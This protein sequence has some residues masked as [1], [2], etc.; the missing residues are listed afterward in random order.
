MS[1]AVK[2]YVIILDLLNS[3]QEGEYIPANTF[4][5][6]FDKHEIPNS[7]SAFNRD[8]KQLQEI[9]FKINN[10]KRQ[11]YSLDKEA[12]NRFD[13]LINIFKRLAVEQAIN[14]SEILKNDTHLY[15]SLEP[16]SSSF[17][18][19][20]NFDLILQAIKA[21]QK[22]TFEHTSFYHTLRKAPKIYTLA[23][24]LLK[25]FQNR[26][27]VIGETAEG[28]RTFGLDRITMLQV[29]SKK[30]AFKNKTEQ[31]ND[32]LYHTVGLNFSDYNPQQ[33]ILKVHKS[34]EPYLQSLPLHHSQKTIHLN[35]TDKGHV[36]L[37]LFVTYNLE[38]KQ[39]LLKYGAFLEVLEP[40]FV[41]ND[42][43]DTL[44]KASQLYK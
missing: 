39:Q 19:F 24:H 22:I 35:E 11:G 33:I 16:T 20:K 8:I 1:N 23:P 36:I 28:F 5:V 2:R 9:G 44:K 41:R 4:Y 32:L 43:A 6:H 13:F 3:A 40:E 10:S 25:E 30:N 26:W 27:Y 12:T 21:K 38:L 14:T 34:Q 42:M 15:L 7:S 17:A 31:A 18:S 29:L 37:Q